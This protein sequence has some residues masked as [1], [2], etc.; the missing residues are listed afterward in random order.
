MCL[1]LT[2]TC[3]NVAEDGL[4]LLRNSGEIENN[5]HIIGEIVTTPTSLQKIYGS[6]KDET[7]AK[8]K[9]T[10]IKCKTQCGLAWVSSQHGSKEP[11]PNT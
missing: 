6:N 3:R 11:G 7:Q 4:K 8:C 1:Q 5:P 10:L 2:S 9:G